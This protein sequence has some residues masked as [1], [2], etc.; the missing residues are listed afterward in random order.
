MVGHD[1]NQV[2]VH[3]NLILPKADHI[4]SNQHRRLN[5]TR[6][7]QCYRSQLQ[8]HIV[9][10]AIHVGATRR[11]A[12]HRG[13]HQVNLALQLSD[14]L[15]DH[16]VSDVAPHYVDAREALA[17]LL[18]A[19]RAHLHRIHVLRL[20]AHRFAR[21]E[22]SPDAAEQAQHRQSPLERRPPLLAVRHR[23]VHRPLV[24][25]VRHAMQGSGHLLQ[26]LSVTRA[27][28][29]FGQRRG[30]GQPVVLARVQLPQ[31][32][33]EVGLRH[34][35][36]LVLL[37]L[38][39][40]LPWEVNPHRVGQD[41][42]RSVLVHPPRRTQRL[43]NL[44]LRE[45]LPFLGRHTVHVQGARVA[46]RLVLVHRRDL[47]HAP[48]SHLSLLLHVVDRCAPIVEYAV[49]V[50]HCHHA[51]SVVTKV[52]AQRSPFSHTFMFFSFA[53][54]IVGSRSLPPSTRPRC[55]FRGVPFFSLVL[56]FL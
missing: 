27:H 20:D 24:G 22:I 47:G 7:L 53:S 8:S 35:A 54:P 33:Q 56:F 9:L 36:S 25:E 21:G 50:L 30:D 26:E 1:P 31:H 45:A 44:L 55:S 37:H 14:P 43:V 29:M 13:D 4:L 40:P 51:P 2:L 3:L 23:A 41:S 39:G 52:P 42:H 48:P 32:F 6:Q 12:R 16:R 28:A 10:L 34:L 17:Q 15:L 19:L 49:L 38:T 5:L 46:H 18:L 11:L